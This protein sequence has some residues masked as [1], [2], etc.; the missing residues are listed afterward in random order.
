M[1]ALGDVRSLRISRR[2]RSCLLRQWL[3]LLHTSGAVL[4]SG[5]GIHRRALGFGGKLGGYALIQKLIS[6]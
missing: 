3:R 6:R 1:Q 5:T 4:L 2:A